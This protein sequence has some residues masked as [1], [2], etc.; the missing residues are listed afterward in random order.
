M[1]GKVSFLKPLGLC[2]VQPYFSKS[3]QLAD[4]IEWVICQIGRADI[5]IS[6]FSTSEEFLRR[7]FRMKQKGLVRSCELICDLRAARKTISLKNF[8]AST[9]DCV[10]LSQNHSKVVLLSSGLNKV[11]IVTS[12]NQT[13]GDRYEAGVVTSDLFTFNTLKEGLKECIAN[14]ILIS[15]LNEQ[16]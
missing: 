5:T 10:Y 12:Q 16:V 2:A 7:M 15:D 11:A 4:L 14:S 9:F 1:S 8:M 13:R 6:T 3:V